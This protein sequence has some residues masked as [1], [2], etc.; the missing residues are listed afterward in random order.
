M[1]M[2]LFGFAVFASGG[3]HFSKE[4]KTSNPGRVNSGASDYF[5]SIAPGGPWSAVATWETSSDNINWVPAALTPT[6]AA[7]TIS[8]INGCTVTVS[9]A[10]N[11]DQVVIESGGILIHSANT[12]TVNDGVGDDI[13]VQSG[14][15]FTLAS[16][17]NAPAFPI[18]TARVNIRTGGILRVSATGVTGAGSDVNSNNFVYQDASVLEYTLIFAFS[19]SN[20]T[21]FPNANASTI[22]IF[23]T[24][25]SLG[26]IGGS[27]GNTTTF[28]GVFECNGTITFNLAGDKIFRNGITGTGNIGSSANCGK[29]FITGATAKI[30]GAGSVTLPTAAA[31]GLDIGNNT[32]VTMTGDKTFTGNITLLNNALV[33]LGAYNLTVAGTVNGG[34][35]TSHVVTNGTGKLVINNIGASAVQFPVG[36]TPASYIPLTLSNGGGFNYAVRTAAT[37]N[38]PIVITTQAVNRTWYVTCSGTPPGNVGTIFQ[39]AAADCNVSWAPPPAKQELGFYTTAWNVIQTNLTQA[40]ADP[41]QVTTSVNM[42]AATLEAPLVLAN[43]GAILAAD[44]PVTINYFTGIKQNNKHTLNWKLTCNSTVAVTIV[45]ERSNDAVNYNKVYEEYAT[46]L[47]CAQPFS[48]T[49]VQ[50]LAGVNYYRIKM[51]DV[52]GKISY[53]S[54]VPL[55]NALHGITVLNIAPNPVTTG[56]FNLAV[57][58]ANSQNATVSITDL[59]GRFL[60]KQA[61]SLTASYNVLPV[62]VRALPAGSYL[63]QLLTQQERRTL[64]FVVQ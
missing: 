22:P 51:I 12:L 63:L 60:Q 57:S 59:Q 37:I 49:D 33:T 54:I 2:L 27:T 34:S 15:V 10:Q 64:R 39:Y 36:P 14:G 1:G 25:N 16:N 32:S 29:F 46:A 42:F 21:Y 17:G 6:S 18:A 47:R 13:D 3:L 48:Y 58:T 30:G 23:R 45:L 31:S 41:Y 53:S 55:L 9:T 50:P 20:V 7:N 8:I 26:L 11:M 4:E 24:T 40:G 35:A 19:S 56:S 44:N 38:P 62:N 43:I 5:R 28:N 52:D 61:V